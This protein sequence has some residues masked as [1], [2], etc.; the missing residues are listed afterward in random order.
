M[1]QQY[2][3]KRQDRDFHRIIWRSSSVEPVQT[4]R[5][6]RV[7]YGNAAASSHSIRASTEFAYQP[8]VTND[9]QEVFGRDFYVDDI[10]T[11]A[12]SIEQA[13][14]LQKDLISGLERKKFDLRKWTCSDPSI[15]LSLPPEYREA[16]ES[17]EFP[18]KNHTI[19]TLG[20]VWS[21]SHENFSFRIQRLD[22]SWTMPK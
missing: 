14:A 19:K 6:T 20:V 18:D 17:F 12:R 13:E 2:E 11:G 15:T 8:N 5:I 1:Y 9:V 3:R 21:P 4:L 7:T 22:Q 16:N 10:L